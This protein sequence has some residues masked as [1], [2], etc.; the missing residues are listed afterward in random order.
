MRYS[1]FFTSIIAIAIALSGC[2]LIDYVRDTQEELKWPDNFAF[3]DTPGEKITGMS[4]TVAKRD[5]VSGKMS[6]VTFV[7][8]WQRLKPGEATEFFIYEDVPSTGLGHKKIL[9]QA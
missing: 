3:S 1:K 9:D 6:K 4:W 7:R 2:Q 8:Y 5:D